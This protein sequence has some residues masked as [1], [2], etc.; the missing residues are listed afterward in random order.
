[1][2]K[3]YLISIPVYEN[4]EVEIVADE[5]KSEK[6]IK[7]KAIEKAIKEQ[8]KVFWMVDDNFDIEINEVK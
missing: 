3:K 4:I 2:K 8:P 7:D 5:S 1:M 6:S